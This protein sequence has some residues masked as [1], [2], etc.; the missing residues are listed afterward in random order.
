MR[1]W[2][3]TSGASDDWR[4]STRRYR[5]SSKLSAG[6]PDE[7]KVAYRE[8]A[9]RLGISMS[10]LTRRLAAT[11]LTPPVV[12]V[13]LCEDCH[14]ELPPSANGRASHRRKCSGARPWARTYF[15]EH[16]KWP[17]GAHHEVAPTRKGRVAGQR[18]KQKEIGG[19]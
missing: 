12:T 6:M 3:P 2:N 16:G 4:L 5:M 17:K 8:A 19:S 18:A 9:A 13:R 14:T 11:T 7:M 10:E 1:A 15:H